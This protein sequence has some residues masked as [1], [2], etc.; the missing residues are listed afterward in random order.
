[1]FHVKRSHMRLPLEVTPLPAVIVATRRFRQYVALPSDLAGSPLEPGQ[2]ES[3][4][5]GS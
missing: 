5:L 4:R 3:A 1:M 2:D